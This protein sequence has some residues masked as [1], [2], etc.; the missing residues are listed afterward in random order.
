MDIRQKL[1]AVQDEKYR[2]FSRKLLPPSTKIIGVRLPLL[3][4]TAKQIAKT[5]WQKFLNCTKHDYFEEIMLEGFV[6]AYAP[7][8]FPAREKLIRKFVPKINNWSICDSF[9]AS[10]NL[11]KE[12]ELYLPLIKSY[13]P[14]TNEYKQRFAIVMLLDHYFD[15][16]YADTA[17]SLINSAAAQTY[18]AKMAKA[19]AISKYFTLYPA[20]GFSFLQKKSLDEQTFKMTLQKIRDSRRVDNA[21][22]I[23]LKNL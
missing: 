22:K 1:F 15:V 6:I 20:K 2:E 11:K 21:V 13:L 7:I 9:C 18:I 3:R 19:W 14:S 10:F 17:L 5:D 4:Q 8:D 12:Q 16:Q 23:Q